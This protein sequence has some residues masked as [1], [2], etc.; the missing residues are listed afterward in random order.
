MK[1][2][3][4]NIIFFLLG[5]LIAYLLIDKEKEVIEVPVEFEV[6]VPVFQKEFDTIK[7]IEYVKVKDVDTSLVS[8]FRKA[9]DSLK[10]QLFI[11]QS[12]YKQY[13]QKFEDSLQTIT[14]SA[15][16]TSLRSLSASYKTKPFSVKVDTVLQYE[17]A[18]PKMEFSLYIEGGVPTSILNPGIVGKAGVDVKN[19]KGLIYGISFDTE[20][21]LW[22]KIGKTFKF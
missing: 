6:E 20:Q 9:N 12:T 15:E 16:A 4:Y 1:N 17:I 22:G 11:Q 2:I 5:A 14:V 19:K 18:P 8:K 3:H 7:S 10:E 21:R 13:T